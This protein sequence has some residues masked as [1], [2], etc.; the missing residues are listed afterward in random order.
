MVSGRGS[1]RLEPG[2]RPLWTL[3]LKVS[4]MDPILAPHVAGPG[5]GA[6]AWAVWWEPVSSVTGREGEL[7]QKLVS[8]LHVSPFVIV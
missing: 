6:S 8:P 3:L 4:Q 7:L 1:G 2:R 5:S